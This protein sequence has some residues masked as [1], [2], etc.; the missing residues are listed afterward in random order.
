MPHSAIDVDVSNR[1]LLNGIVVP[2][3]SRNFL[4]VPAVFASV[5][6]NCHNGYC[7]QVVATLRAAGKCIPR[8]TV[9]NS[10]QHKIGLRVI[11][12]G[13]PCGTASTFF[14]PVARPSGSCHFHRRIF[15]S[16]CRVAGHCVEAPELF[17]GFGIIG[18]NVTA[19]NIFGAAVTDKDFAVGN[20]GRAS[21]RVVLGLV[22][23]D[24]APHF[25]AGGSIKRNQAT[26]VGAHI[27]F[28]I[29]C[30]HPAVDDIATAACTELTWHFRIVMPQQGASARVIRIHFAPRLGHVDYAVDEQGSGFLPTVGIEVSKPGQTELADIVRRDL[31]QLAETL[32]FV[33]TAIRH[34]LAGLACGIFKTRFGD[35]GGG[36][37]NTLRFIRCGGCGSLIAAA[38]GHQQC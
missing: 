38:T 15:K 18:T 29:P 30:R 20:T 34:P 19:I 32:L 23:G 22:G 3:F 35:S 16:V 12:N 27:N 21:N 26:V 9:A 31:C 8:R 33:G 4:I 36:R 6:I 25:L 17:A 2:L 1:D 28:A 7:E 37:C 5:G 14:P 13:I 10:K 11:G 24:R